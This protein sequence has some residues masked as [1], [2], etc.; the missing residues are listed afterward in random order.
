M[1]YPKIDK[2]L[3]SYKIAIDSN[4]KI[5][6]AQLAIKNRLFVP[7]WYLRKS[8]IDLMTSDNNTYYDIEL[9]FYGNQPVGICIIDY[10]LFKDLTM[11]YVKPNYR[12]N[13]I[14]T[15]L[16][17]IAK[18]LNND[19]WGADGASRAGLKFFEKTNLDVY[20]Y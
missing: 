11:F 9:C 17:Q 8:L 15:K 13:G 12:R 16:L 5:L 18:N 19:C 4:E 3:L 6:F 20:S 7:G 14:G 2:Y 10:E 1:R